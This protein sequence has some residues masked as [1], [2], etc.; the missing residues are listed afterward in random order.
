MSRPI[1]KTDAALCV[2]MEETKPLPLHFPGYRTNPD[3]SRAI[4][5]SYAP[6][7]YELFPIAPSGLQLV[8][9]DKQVWASNTPSAA[10]CP[11]WKQ[12][13]R[14]L[15]RPYSFTK[16]YEQAHPGDPS[17]IPFLRGEAYRALVKTCIGFKSTSLLKYYVFAA[18]L[19]YYVTVRDRWMVIDVC[20]S[21]PEPDVGLPSVV[22]MLFRDL[23]WAY[24]ECPEHPRIDGLN[25]ERCAQ[26][27]PLSLLVLCVMEGVERDNPGLFDPDEVGNFCS[28]KLYKNYMQTVT[29]MR[30]REIVPCNLVQ[31]IKESWPH[32][33]A[34]NVAM[35]AGKFYAHPNAIGMLELE[36]NKNDLVSCRTPRIFSHLFLS[37]FEPILPLLP[38]H[39]HIYA[40]LPFHPL[41]KLDKPL[42]DYVGQLPDRAQTDHIYKGVAT[43][44]ACVKQRYC[45][46]VADNVAYHYV[47]ELYTPDQCENVPD[48]PTAMWLL[49]IRK[50]RKTE[51]TW[52]F[53]VVYEE[54]L[55]LQQLVKPCNLLP[56]LDSTYTSV[57]CNFRKAQLHTEVQAFI[58][59]F[60]RD[61]EAASP[62]TY[63]QLNALSL[64]QAVV[65]PDMA[66][67][68]SEFLTIYEHSS[69]N[70]A[71]CQQRI[72][73]DLNVHGDIRD[74]TV[75][76]IEK[77]L[78]GKTH[79]DTLDALVHVFSCQDIFTHS[80]FQKFKLTPLAKALASHSDLFRKFTQ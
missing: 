24:V 51:A 21:K 11:L 16:Q 20:H 49:Q 22:F 65:P 78:R 31:A 41:G 29:T 53:R 48:I 73:Y 12:A 66:Q 6:H 18:T 4:V 55:S 44:P 2:R 23:D 43:T 61:P 15:Y 70:M 13:F 54:G 7:V 32:E 74:C 50:E 52:C 58:D 67:R 75:Y 37:P 38:G 77:I 30:F 69:S 1:P 3:G 60:K 62:P 40:V 28:N 47:P 42:K 56:T 26:A 68:I 46:F 76:D 25:I 39:A 8:D 36:D 14:H 17:V 57:R 45:F 80:K 63:E 64:M 5:P 27:L 9:L 59:A 71:S 72:L 79:L 35:R 10:W 34:P 19:Q 33:T